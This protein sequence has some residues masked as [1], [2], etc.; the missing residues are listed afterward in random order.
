MPDLI[1]VEA[2]Y[3]LSEGS[4]PPEW[5]MWMPAGKHTIKASKNGRPDVLTLT[6][7]ERDAAKL[8]AELASKTGPE[9]YIGFDHLPGSRASIPLEFAWKTEPKPGIYFKCRWT[10]DGKKAVTAGEGESAN[11]GYFSPTFMADEKGNV[12]GLP[13]SGEIGSLTNNPA[14]R[15]ILKVAASEPSTANNMTEAESAAL[16]A[17][18]ETLK[19]AKAASDAELKKTKESVACAAVAQAVNDGKIAAQDTAKQDRYKALIVEDAANAALLDD[20][21]VKF[22]ATKAANVGG[23]TAQGVTKDAGFVVGEQ[24]IKR[25]ADLCNA[26]EAKGNPIGWHAAWQ[27]AR[28]ELGN[29]PSTEKQSA[30]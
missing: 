20:L 25:A 18:I 22:T 26:S 27:Q 1:Q 2:A 6:V 7:T 19:A 23:Q 3:A 15:E 11:Y 29:L 5:V 14:F 8:Q 9:H 16:K 30:A 4:T 12:T 21:P 24:I 17:E 13:P 10:P 28:E